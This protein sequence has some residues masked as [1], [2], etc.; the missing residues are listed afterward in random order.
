MNKD[1]KAPIGICLPDELST[2][3]YTPS[4]GLPIGTLDNPL[5]AF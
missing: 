4:T 5:N 1:P 2:D 3:K